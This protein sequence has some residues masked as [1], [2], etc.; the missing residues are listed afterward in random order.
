MV[1]YGALRDVANSGWNP[2]CEVVLI[3]EW[4]RLNVEFCSCIQRGKDENKALCRGWITKSR[5][6]YHPS[7]QLC[8]VI[9]DGNAAAKS[10]F[11]QARKG[12]SFVLTF[13]SERG[14]NATILIAR[15]HALECNVVLA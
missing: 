10:L 6:I 5:E 3:Y 2:S 15:K 1:V 14:R 13:E 8:G 12:L 9:G 11:W 4:P 7:M